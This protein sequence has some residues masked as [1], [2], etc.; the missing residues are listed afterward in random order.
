[1]YNVYMS[2]LAGLVIKNPD[3]LSGTPVIKGTRIPV[4]LLVSLIQK[5]YTDDLIN[6]EYPSL[7]R[8]KISAFKAHMKAE[9]HAA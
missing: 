8:K 9:R 3:I 7:S 4:S 2:T 1:M 5:G 6:T